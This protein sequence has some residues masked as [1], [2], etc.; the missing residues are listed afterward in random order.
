MSRPRRINVALIAGELSGG[1]AER[2][3]ELLATGLDPESF[4]VTI[5]EL[6]GSGEK[7][8]G[9]RAKGYEVVSFV[10]DGNPKRT[11]LNFWRLRK[12]VHRRRIDLIHSHSASALA[13]A[14][15]CKLLTPHLRL[16]H[17]FHYGNYPHL[18]ASS[19][20]IERWGHRLLDAMVA[21]G[22]RQAEAIRRTYGVPIARMNVIWNGID[23]RPSRADREL[24]APYLG[25]GRVIIGTI[26]TLFEQ[27]GH[28]DL[29]EV[30]GLLKARGLPVTFLIVGAG[31]LW[32][33]LNE[34]C[35]AMGLGDY[36]KFLGWVENAADRVMGAIDIFFQPSRWEAMSMVLLEAAA[37]GK[38][39]VCTD[40]GEASRILKDGVSAFMTKPGDI[41]AM[42]DRLEKLV[43]A[44]DLRNRLGGAARASIEQNCTAEAMTRHYEALYLD[45]VSTENKRSRSTTRR[46]SAVPEH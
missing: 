42:T 35:E 19:M 36:V 43:F 30:A 17:T 22:F 20:R 11:Y 13:D 1:G 38:P 21:V 7:A 23:M 16:V 40:V 18:D 6:L 24:L 4:G 39:I 3:L 37:A 28:V 45:V 5:V 2:V 27:K 25:R 46:V 33:A 32:Q 14:A 34:R 41:S 44:Q 26:G 10:P 12:L 8:V 29:L 31:P 9:L 15:L